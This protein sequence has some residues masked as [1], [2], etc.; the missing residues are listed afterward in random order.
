M[1]WKKVTNANTVKEF[2]LEK[3]GKP[4]DDIIKPTGDRFDRFEE[5]KKL[6][7]S[8]IKKG[9]MISLVS[10]YD[11]DGINSTVIMTMLFEILKAKFELIIPKRISEGYGLSDK[12]VERIK[13][14]NLVIT[15]D[16][17]IT[18]VSQI[19]RLKLSGCKVVVMDHHEAE[20]QLPIAD[21]LIDPS[22]IGEADYCN[23]CGAGIA[24]RFAEYILGKEHPVLP[25]LSCFAAIGTIGDVVEL[26]GDNRTI[27][28]EGLSNIKK[29][30]G[31]EGLKRLCEKA[32]IDESSCAMDVAFNVVPVLNAPGRLYDD[33][34]KHSVIS[35]YCNDINMAT[36]YV[37][38]LVE[39]N[40]E[41]QKM[42][43]RIMECIDIDGMIKS[44]DKAIILLND[45]IPLGI[46]GIIAGQISE[47]T[48]RPA[49]VFSHTPEG[50][51]KG[52]VRSKSKDYSIIEII[53]KAQ[54]HLIACGGHAKAAGLEL[55]EENLKSFV[56]CIKRYL[57]EVEVMDYIPYDLEVATGLLPIVARQIIGL[58]PCG[59]GLPSPVIRITCKPVSNKNGENYSF[60]GDKKQ[61]IRFFLPGNIT[62][63]CFNYENIIGK[64]L[65]GEIKSV[66]IIGR[67][68]ENVYKGNKNIQI[69][70]KDFRVS[71]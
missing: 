63:I 42:V 47:K 29:G 32:R 35:M 12:I 23:Y 14:G 64:K 6:L 8:E 43:K 51:L 38:N 24:Y 49:F 56:N 3:T 16:N 71:C 60:M 20:N 41:R 39:I 21:V 62:A 5:A 25:I 15:V 67:I 34:A 50:T 33:G 40:G 45:D 7:Y 13:P 44:K 30:I 53:R 1:E 9:T 11:S 55:K 19:E 58:E 28:S 10:D 22:A 65:E 31:T 17:G 61:H 46:V 70:V 26:S 4:F 59:E 48:N 2:V 52:S 27:V 36:E 66:D 69:I 37:N 54:K 18:A 68:S 57:P